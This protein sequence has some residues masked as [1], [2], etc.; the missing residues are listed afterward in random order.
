MKT[1][2][3]LAKDIVHN[4]TGSV[5]KKILDGTTKILERSS[6][7]EPGKTTVIFK[8]SGWPSWV[9]KIPVFQAAFYSSGQNSSLWGKQFNGPLG[10]IQKFSQII[11]WQILASGTVCLLQSEGFTLF[12]GG[13]L[14]FIAHSL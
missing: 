6:E 1:T 11:Q 2:S 7:Q 13:L 3:L 14:H 8:V 4:K 12:L 5:L 9:A 10:E